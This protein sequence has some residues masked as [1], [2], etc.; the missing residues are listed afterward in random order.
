MMKIIEV[1]NYQELSQATSTLIVQKVSDNPAAVLGLAT[2][3][4]P[5]G[6]YKE[7]IKDYKNHGTSYEK[8]KTIN[9]DEYVGLPYTNENSYHYFMK[10][11]LFKHLNFRE[12]NTFIPNGLA[13]HLENACRSYDQLI[14]ENPIDLQ[15]LGIGENGHIGFN[16]PGTSFLSHTHIV[17]LTH[18][19]RKANARFFNHIT[20]VPTHALTMGIASILQSKEILLLASGYKK[21]EAISRLLNG[22]VSEAFPASALNQHHNVTIIAD[23]EALSQA[24]D[25]KRSIK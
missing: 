11:Q 8:V 21:A 24:I 5:I 17:E 12:E 25:Q 19:T 1:E 22:S 16:E 14:K 23:K 10:E 4:T 18:S 13:D 20:E 2:G 6:T 15:I 9:L 7:M 3:S